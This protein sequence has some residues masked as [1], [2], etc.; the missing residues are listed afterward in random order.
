[1]AYGGDFGDE[2]NDYNF[3]MDGLCFANHTPTPGLIEYKKAIEPVQTLSIKG[4]K[5]TIINRYDFV[6]LDHLKCSWKIV[7]DGLEIPGRAVE[8]PKGMYTQ[9][10]PR[11]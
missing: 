7:A 9:G 1:M 10:P 5:A 8:L 6:T 3:V 4:N 2:P 11:F